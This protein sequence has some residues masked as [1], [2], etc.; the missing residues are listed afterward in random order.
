M[1]KSYFDDHFVYDKKRDI[2]W[3]I[4]A[5]HFK[6]P[7]DSVVLD[8]GAGYCHFI[9]SIDVKEKHALDS[10]SNLKKYAKKDVVIHKKCCTKTGLK[11]GCF[12]VV[13]ASNL[14]EHLEKEELD[15]TI[16][17]VKR[18]LKRR[19]KLMI[20]QPN[21]KYAKKDYFIDP[22]HKLVFTHNS[23]A[24]FLKKNGFRIIKVIPRFLPLTV[25]SRFPVIPFLIKL[26][27]WLPFKPLGKQFL[28]VA[29]KV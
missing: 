17:E 16:L 19:G 12:D 11:S 5:D 22:T 28:V 4:L 8:L 27:L 9:N 20:I 15:K 14:F 29:E 21:Y 24:G 6:I 1:D 25:K 2:V 7:Y 3:K 10:V 18:I 26:Y 23:M 13:M